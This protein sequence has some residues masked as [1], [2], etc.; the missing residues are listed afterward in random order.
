MNNVGDLQKAI[1]QSEFDY[2]VEGKIL[3]SKKKAAKKIARWW[4]AKKVQRLKDNK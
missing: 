2:E 4:K 3:E 1:D